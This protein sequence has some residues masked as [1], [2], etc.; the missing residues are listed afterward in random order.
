[1]TCATP[2]P[3]RAP[4]GVD[5]VPEL[6]VIGSHATEAWV[7]CRDCG[8]WF[9]TSTDLGGKFDYVGEKPLD[10][11]LA[12]RAFLAGDARAAARLLVETDEPYG[13]IWTTASALIE[14]LRAATPSANDRARSEALDAA[15]P[16]G[17]WI[18][19]AKVLRE[20]AKHAP[21][22]ASELVFELDARMPG[23]TLGD[24]YEI[25]DAL[26]VFQ[27][28]PTAEMIR[29]TRAGGVGSAPLPATAARGSGR[30]RISAGNTSM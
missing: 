12:E 7:R 11:E 8:A 16:C 6:E 28:A 24:A 23:R 26:V 5:L 1:M 30:R 15:M 10:R 29:I 27:D 2:H 3:V 4:G 17:R 9:W 20:L 13:P 19:A 21:P 18:A 22:S 25:G 14:M